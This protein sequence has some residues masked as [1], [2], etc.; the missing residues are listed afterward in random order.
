MEILLDGNRYA[1][2]KS[3]TL[4]PNVVFETASLMLNE[5]SG[6]DMKYQ[7]IYLVERTL[8]ICPSVSGLL[9]TYSPPTYIIILI[10]V[11]FIMNSNL[12]RV[13]VKLYKTAKTC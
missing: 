1:K 2:E 5:K 4:L 12:E 13:H 8:M 9:C 10:Y 11:I 7:K 6:F 3:E